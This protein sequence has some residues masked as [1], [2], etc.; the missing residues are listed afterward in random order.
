MR[1]IYKA[2]SEPKDILI[3]APT[4]I[5]KTDAAIGAALAYAVDNKLDVF[6][7]TPK[8]SQHKVAIESLLGIKKKFNPEV[9]Y[10][11][12]VGKRNLCINTDVNNIDGE[13]FYKS[14]ENAVSSKKCSFYTNAKDTSNITP[15]VVDASHLGHNALFDKSFKRGLC[16]YEVATYLAKDANFVIA[17]Y[18]HILN[19]YTK[20]SFLKRIAH[21]MENSIVIWDE[22]H[23]VL[24]AASSYLSSSITSNTIVNAARELYAIKSSIDIGYLD[25]MIQ[26]IAEKR[27]NGRTEAFVESDDIEKSFLENI[28]VVSEQLEKAGLE[29]ITKAKAK[30]SSLVHI[31]KFLLSL[32]G[33]DESVASIVSKNGK[34]VKIALTCLYPQKSVD[35]FKEPF[36]NIFMSGTLLP[37]HMYREL[38]GLE[39]A[40]IKDYTSGFPKGNKVCVIDQ[41]VSTKYDT[42]SESE[43]KKIAE[44]I[45]AVRKETRGNIA[46]FFPGFNVLNSVHRHMHTMVDFIQRREMKSV[47]V[48]SFIDNFKK[49]DDSIMFGVMGGSMSEGVDY[50]NN[51]IKGIIIVGIPLEKPNLELNARIEYM[52]RKFDGKGNEYAYIIPGVIRAAQAAGRA[53]RSEKDRA[54]IVFMDKRYGWSNYKSL[55]SNFVE[56]SDEKDGMAAIK[57]FVDEGKK[58]LIANE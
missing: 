42:R 23:N 49:S 7:L 13:A 32:K 14:C 36:A 39:E 55:I 57:K 15:D 6:F 50:A 5:G 19:P 26:S 3:N 38:F 51:V 12:I 52:N 16:A 4:G 44:R 25:F 31:S 30:R 2:V 45:E 22:A 18:A 10:I 54:F 46:V 53:I 20:H 21:R 58:K 9:R 8:I 1:D 56:I 47:S 27:L 28:P 17:D 40:M 41:S 48:E 24:S 29:Y 11:D 37:L 33:R 35:L 43:Y 34:T